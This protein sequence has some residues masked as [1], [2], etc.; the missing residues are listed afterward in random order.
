MH[1]TNQVQLSSKVVEVIV[2]SLNRVGLFETP[3]TVAHQAPLSVGFPR[4]EYWSGLSFPSAGNIPDPGIEPG[5]PALL[6]WAAVPSSRGS[7]KPGIQPRSPTLQ[8]NSSLSEPPGKLKNTGVG[9]L[10]LLQ[11]IFLTQ[12]HNWG[13]PHCRQILYQLSYQGNPGT[14]HIQLFFR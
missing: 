5:S 14:W 6:E 7:S 4:Q 11:G 8:A 9:S 10:S 2:Q 1:Q 12:E 3:W 13:L